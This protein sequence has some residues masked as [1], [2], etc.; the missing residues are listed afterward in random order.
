MG[1]L[2]LVPSRVCVVSMPTGIRLR[3]RRNCRILR[4]TYGC[5]IY[6]FAN[7]APDR[8]TGLFLALLR[9]RARAMQ[10]LTK[11]L[12]WISWAA[13]GATLVFC[14]G[15][16]HVFATG[17]DQLTRDLRLDSAPEASLVYDRHNNL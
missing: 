10:R 6:E 3:S 2:W 16:L 8:P 4:G 12:Q 7:R 13:A 9:L 5:M 15:S 1:R 11:V 14:L 17:L